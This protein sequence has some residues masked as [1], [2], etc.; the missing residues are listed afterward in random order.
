MHSLW[1]CFWV[2]RWTALPVL[3]P[4]WRILIF[5][6][7]RFKTFSC[8]HSAFSA[9]W[10][11]WFTVVVTDGCTKKWGWWV[12]PKIGCKK[13]FLVIYCLFFVFLQAQLGLWTICVTVF[14]HMRRWELYIHQ[15]ADQI[16]VVIVLMFV[17]CVLIIK[18]N[19]IYWNYM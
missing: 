9:S 3:P 10:Q 15:W 14:V 16:L 2:M 17:T 8:N 19:V 13:V 18:H 7:W 6:L 12:S 4:R 11:D 1:D 5:P